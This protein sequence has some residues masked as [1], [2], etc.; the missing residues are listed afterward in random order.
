[1]IHAGQS[2][3]FASCGACGNAMNAG[4]TARPI[5]AGICDSCFAVLSSG[6]QAKSREI[7]QAIDAPILLMQPNPRQVFAANGRALALF[8]KTLAEAEGHRGGEGFNCVHSFSA[9]GC[10]KD[11]H[12]EDCKIKAAIVGAF[13]GEESS[14]MSTLT[15]RRG[16]DAPYTLAIATEH[17]GSYALVRIDRFGSE[18]GGPE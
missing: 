1:M 12:C 9:D 6:E 14:A 15:I 11:I 10:G 3:P 18:N 13:T 7:L 17:A 16:H 4:E 8:G 5:S 2:S